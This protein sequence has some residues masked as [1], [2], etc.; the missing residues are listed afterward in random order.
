MGEI[1]FLAVITAVIGYLYILTGSFP[2]N[3]LDTTGGAAMFPRVVIIVLALLIVIRI[4]QII[5]NKELKV[6]FVFFELLKGSTGIFL[7]SLVAYIFLFSI[8]GYVVATILYLVLTITYC[9]YKKYGNIGSAKAVIIR[10]ALSVAGTLV[11]YWFFT[12]V[13]LVR[14]PAGILKL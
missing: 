7:L 13:L 1:I 11:L 14:M 6:H 8:L 12:S 10:V 5:K 9:Y 4:I 3:A 2:V